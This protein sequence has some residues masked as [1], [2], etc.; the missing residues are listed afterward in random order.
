MV[1]T[2]LFFFLTKPFTLLDN[3][4]SRVVLDRLIYFSPRGFNVTFTVI[5]R[6][7]A[8]VF[9]WLTNAFG[10]ISAI[11]WHHCK[12]VYCLLHIVNFLSSTERLGQRLNGKI[13]LGLFLMQYPSSSVYS[14]KIKTFKFND[15][16]CH[17]GRSL[18][19]FC[20]FLLWYVSLTLILIA[21]IN[22]L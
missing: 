17:A 14:L 21:I 18:I 22:Y 15:W 12:D 5:Y 20:W 16:K 4:H 8:R 3:A 1:N 6:L 11:L 13:T 7:S 10:I 2:F 9:K 19:F